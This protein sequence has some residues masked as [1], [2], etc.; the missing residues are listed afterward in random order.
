MSKAQ[1]RQRTGRAGREREGTCYRLTHFPSHSLRD[2]FLPSL[3]IF[4][5]I[6]LVTASQF[7]A[8]EESTVPEIQ[9]SNLC[10]VVLTM[11]SIG[12]NDILSFDF[13]DSPGREDMKSALR[14][15]RLLGALSPEVVGGDN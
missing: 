14:Q 5:P 10:S 9:R 11:L 12:I 7:D 2:L 4:Y 13:M 6:R 8:F 3:T 1:A 15:L